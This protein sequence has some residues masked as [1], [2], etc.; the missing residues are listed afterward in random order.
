MATRTHVPLGA[1]AAILKPSEVVPESSVPVLGPQF[2]RQYNLQDFLA[3][4][5]QI[6]FQAT[7]LSRAIEIVN[8]MV[9][10]QDVDLF[11]V[12]FPSAIAYMASFRRRTY[13]EQPR[14]IP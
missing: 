12:N 7:S 6:G 2:D 4:Y 3:S 5:Q 1:S 11:I 10:H 13:R 14:R 8:R 9:R